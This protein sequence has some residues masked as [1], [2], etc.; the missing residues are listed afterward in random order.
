MT[1]E[2][3]WQRHCFFDYHRQHGVDIKVIRIFN[4]Y[5]P[6][7]R[8]DDGR[9]ISNFIIQALKGDDIT[10]YGDGMQTRS[11]CYVDDLVEGMMKMMDSQNDFTGPVNLGNP[12]E[13]TMIHLAETI[14]KMTDSKSKL[15]YMALPQ[16]DPVQR[17]PVIELAKKELN[18]NQ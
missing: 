8:P 4:T 11:F 2:K 18:W 6:R 15:K 17:K 12:N 10:I 7:M 3:G 13:I 16:D 5:G 9:V 1:K 14:I